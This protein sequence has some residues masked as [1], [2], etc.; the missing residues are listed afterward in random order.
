M[1]NICDITGKHVITGNLVSKANNK[2]KRKFYPNLQ[3]KRFFLKELNTWIV[4]CVCT[5]AMRT[6]SKNGLY[7]T[8]KKALAQ[9]TLTS[10]LVQL[11][12]SL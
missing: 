1:A 12:R 5:K 4:L 2:T 9:G 7:L 8:L 3:Q 11:V 10:R 6:I